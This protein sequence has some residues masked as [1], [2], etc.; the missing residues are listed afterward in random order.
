MPFNAKNIFL[1]TFGNNGCH[2]CEKANANVVKSAS[3]ATK[4]AKSLKKYSVSAYAK[5]LAAPMC[6][7]TNVNQVKAGR[8][9]LNIKRFA[10]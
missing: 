2:G 4:S 6:S 9:I 5:F 1:I 10:V 8:K 3:V 7:R